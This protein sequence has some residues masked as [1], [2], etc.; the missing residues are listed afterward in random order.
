MSLDLSKL[1][2]AEKWGTE[3]ETDRG[4]IGG[5]FGRTFFGTTPNTFDLL[6]ATADANWMFLARL[7]FDVMLRRGWHASKDGSRWCVLLPGVASKSYADPFT[8]LVEADAWYR[9]HVEGCDPTPPA[10]PS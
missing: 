3:V 5:D 9:Q 8:A 2:P 1:S 7:A 6:V 4:R 10:V